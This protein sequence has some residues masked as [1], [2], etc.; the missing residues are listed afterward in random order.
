MKDQVTKYRA[1]RQ[2]KEYD[3]MNLSMWEAVVM[4]LVIFLAS[5]MIKL[6]QIVVVPVVW[7]LILGVS[8]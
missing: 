2:R 1:S 5:V 4:V 8:I 7:R 6:Y 3:H